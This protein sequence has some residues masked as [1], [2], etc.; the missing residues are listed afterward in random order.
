MRDMKNT[1]RIAIAVAVVGALCGTFVLAQSV[2]GKPAD[3]RTRAEAA[4][5][6]KLGQLIYYYKPSEAQ[7]A[8][9]KEVLVV[10]FK[11]IEDQNNIRAPKIQALDDEIV[12]V[13]EKI[14]VEQKKIDKLQKGIDALKKE[15]AAVQKHKGVYDTARAELLLD[16]KAEINNVVGKELRVAR[17]TRQIRGSAVSSY[18][19]A[20]LPK[21]AQDSIAAQCETIAEE[22]INAG[23]GDDEKAVYGAYRKVRE[24]AK[25]VVTPAVRLAGDTESLMRSTL[26]RFER[27]KVT[28]AQK[29]KIRDMCAKAARLKVETYA[30]YDKINKDRVALDKDRDV[31]R[32]T[33]SRM[34]QSSYYY[35]VRDEAIQSVLTD[36]QLKAGGFKRK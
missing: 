1:T 21:A 10:Q 4:T 12:A 25:T 20:A 6:E 33:I 17:L 5:R 31:V 24:D 26:R 15:I 34:S 2:A 28:D 30:R 19:F 27:I 29:A 36:E 22:L 35:T 3:F 18:H 8:K 13:N 23:K 7:K 32:R 16:H 11:D 9:I 14:A